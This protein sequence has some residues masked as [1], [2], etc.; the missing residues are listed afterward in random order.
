MTE[1]EKILDQF[2]VA[3]ACHPDLHWMA[4][5]PHKKSLLA[6]F[7]MGWVSGLHHAACDISDKVGDLTQE[8]N[9]DLNEG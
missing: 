3:I 8:T 7:R 9:K 5:S 2:K 4:S 6:L 1:K